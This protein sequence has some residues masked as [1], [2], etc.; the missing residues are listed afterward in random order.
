MTYSIYHLFYSLVISKK[1]FL[2][3]KKLEDFP[4]NKRL[5]SCRN[6]GAFP[7]MAIRLNKNRSAFTGGELIELKDSATYV[8]SSFNSTIPSRKKEIADIISG[9]NSK[10]KQQMVKAGN[11]IDSL[12]VRDVFYLV[13]GKERGN[14]KV[15]LVY[16]S[17]FETISIEELISQAFSQVIE[18][19][20]TESGTDI[21]QALKDKLLS[22][23]SQ[24]E[25]FSKVRDIEKASV[26][27]RFRIMTEVKAEGNILNT[28]KYP[29]IKDNTLNFVLPC[30]D[31]TEEKDTIEKAKLVFSKSE[32]EQFSI[33]KLKHHFNGYFIVFQTPI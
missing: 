14:T 22:I 28:E 27:L 3:V 18:E 26:K 30:H 6:K 29:Q 12:P 11:N 8:V 5:L 23:F 19:R 21:P 24:Q 15:C 9:K 2:N 17:F 13:R 10:I 4:F 32:L 33:F 25:N 16:G 7:D 31:D 1:S 20:L